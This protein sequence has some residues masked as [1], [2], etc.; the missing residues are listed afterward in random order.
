V[1]LL[2]VR[3]VGSMGDEVALDQQVKEPAGND[4]DGNFCEV[5]YP[6]QFVVEAKAA[7]E[8]VSKTIT[9]VWAR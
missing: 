3:F 6:V 2:Q 4:S 5:S 1:P 7:Y 9:S 8:G